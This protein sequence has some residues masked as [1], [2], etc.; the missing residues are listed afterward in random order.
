M[1]DVQDLSRQG[2]P[3][4]TFHLGAGELV[5]LSG[6]SG[7][8]K[9]QL[10]RALVDLDVNSGLV[11]LKT[12]AREQM[13]PA[14]WRTRVALL[15]AESRWWAPTVGEHFSA[16]D[17]QYFEQL[18]FAVDEV[19]GWKVERLS[20]GEKQRLALLRLLAGKP[21]VLLLDEPTANLD[22]DNTRRVEAL[23]RDYLQSHQAACL[24]VSHDKA[25][26]ERIAG[27]VMMM[28]GQGLRDAA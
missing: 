4:I 23:L 7:C 21:D 16:V 19:V 24:W 3:L 9:T 2:L 25:Q 6:P 18:G 13:D 26:I 1:F 10:L 27:R 12:T 8:G 22:D 11:S 14:Q 15:S 17:R 20:S 28:N 5:C